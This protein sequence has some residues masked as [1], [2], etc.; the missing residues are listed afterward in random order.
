MTKGLRPGL[1]AITDNALTP[2][3]TLIESVEAALRGGAVMV[4]YRDKMAP[5]AER[6]SQA[7]NLQAACRNA[8][9]PLVIN[10]DPE[11][12]NRVGA[13]GVHMGQTDGSL[14]AARRRLGDQAIIGIT[15]HADLALAQAGLDAGADYLAFGRF[16]TSSTKPGAP[17]ASPG[18]LTEAKRFDRPLA[19]IGG[20]T[21]D[22]GETLIRAGAD[23]L[24]VVGGLFGGST[25][26]I[27]RRAKAFE[28]LFAAHHPLF[29]IPE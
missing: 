27:E 19:A 22:N 5:A 3:A 10:D 11:L 2:P 1:Y 9:V 24:A 29:S 23:M 21:L 6:L 15:C 13:A 17:A 8:G 20:V 4:Q 26:D 7:T 16:Y 25:N 12:A 18:V 14:T 28:R